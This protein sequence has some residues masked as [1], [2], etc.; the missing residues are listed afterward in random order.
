MNQLPEGDVTYASGNA[1]SA[2]GFSVGAQPD[3]AATSRTT[4]NDSVPSEALAYQLPTSAGSGSKLPMLYVA[5]G[6]AVVAVAGYFFFA[7]GKSTEIVEPTPT[8]VAIETTTT[9]TLPSSVKFAPGSPESLSV[10]FAESYMSFDGSQGMQVWRDSFRASC[11]DQLN[12][13]IEQNYPDFMVG[14]IAKSIY[15]AV[16]T[17]VKPA[18]D[19]SDVYLVS[20]DSYRYRLDMSPQSKEQ[21]LL[22]VT[23]RNVDNNLKVALV[24]ELDAKTGDVKTN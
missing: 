16:I 21:R 1:F 12:E 11:T 7:G 23:L 3:A 6:L 24:E 22:R 19:S 14:D 18:E 15:R 17:D 20:A 2:R 9:T 10:R 8:S 13:A 5:G 4:A